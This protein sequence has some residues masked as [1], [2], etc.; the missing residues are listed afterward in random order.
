MLILAVWNY[1]TLAVFQWHGAPFPWAELVLAAH[2]W[3]WLNLNPL[4]WEI[5]LGNSRPAPVALIPEREL[6]VIIVQSLS[7]VQLFMNSSTPG[8]PVLHHL[9]EFA[10]THV[11][12][13]A[14]AIQPSYPLLPSS[15]P[16]FNLSQHQGLFQWLGSSHQVAKV[17]ELQLEHQ[18][19][20]RICPLGLTGLI[21]LLSKGLSRVVSITTIQNHKSISW[22]SGF[23]T[24]QLSHPYMTTGKAYL[25]L[26]IKK[27]KE[28]RQTRDDEGGRHHGTEVMKRIKQ[29]LNIRIYNV[30]DTVL[31]ALHNFI[32]LKA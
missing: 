22:H 28:A 17:L 11:H 13:V 5:P 23:F 14:D 29:S 20:Q 7:R 18:S 15:P 21:S 32:S 3:P 24:V 26:G 10:Q 31:S 25:K 4:Q 8:F 1:V 30:S 12:W 6:I 16:A 19:F 2:C 27:L 9:P